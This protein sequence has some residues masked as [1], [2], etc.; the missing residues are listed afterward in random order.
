LSI[1]DHCKHQFAIHGLAVDLGCEAP[2]LNIAINKALGDFDV[3]EFPEGFQPS[4]GLVRAYEQSV[5]LRHLSPTATPVAVTGSTIELY[6][7]GERFWLIDDRWGLAEVNLLKGQW[8]SW[9]LPQATLGADEIVQ[10]AIVWPLAQ[11][12]RMK[13]LS[14]VPGTAVSRD[15]WSMLILSPF[16]IEPELTALVRSGYKIIGQQWTALREEDGRVA[17]LH[18][19]G[20]V[21]R[22]PAPQLKNT[23]HIEQTSLWLDLTR[24]NLGSSQNHAFCDAVAVVS[25]G[26]RPMPAMRQINRST[27]LATLRQAWPIVELHPQRRQ[28]QIPVKLA[29]QCRCYETQLSRRPEDFLK[30]LDQIRYT[31]GVTIKVPQVTVADALKKK[32]RVPA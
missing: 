2:W 25:T 19:P 26:R 3:N 24:E 20:E 31:S 6:E 16:N 5:V 14:L 32:P 7:E 15:G 22:L 27:A 1:L 4:I 29:A 12:L 8:Q 21:Q 13:G 9:I 11:L 23:S 30:L 28:S 10:N 17:M 18:M